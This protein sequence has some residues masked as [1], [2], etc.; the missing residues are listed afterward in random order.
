MRFRFL[1]LDKNGEEKCTFY[2]MEDLPRLV[3]LNDHPGAPEDSL[4]IR[5]FREIVASEFVEP[6][7][8]FFRRFYDEAL[9]H[10]AK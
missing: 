3:G 5:R 10:G 8:G 9:L 6:N 2:R 1:Y 7:I 4:K